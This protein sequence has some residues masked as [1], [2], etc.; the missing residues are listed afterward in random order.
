MKTIG[1][2]VPDLL[3]R[4]TDGQEVRLSDFPGKNFIIYFYPK[5]NTPG[6]TAE[7][8]D[9]RDNYETFLEMGYVVIGVSKDS[10][11][12]H[13]RFRQ[14]YDLPFIL[15]ADTEHKLCEEFGVWQL[16]KMAGREYMGIVRTTFVVN[17]A[18]EVTDVVKK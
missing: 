9:F 13:A 3:G 10:D 7:A 14:K 2:S 15:I 11:A 16:K 1:D 17:A 5:D 18:H 12:S 6:C 8:C 4:N